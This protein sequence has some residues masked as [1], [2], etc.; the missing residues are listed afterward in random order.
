MRARWEA[1]H[2]SLSASARGLQFNLSFLE[3]KKLHPLLTDFS[4]PGR[5]VAWLHTKDGDLDAKDR[6]LSLLVALAQRGEHREL[7]TTLLWLG[8]WPG[9]DGVYRRRLKHFESQPDELVAE[10]TGAFIALIARL[11]LATVTRVA[12]TLIRSTERDLMNGR[13]RLWAEAQRIQEE[14]VAPEAFDDYLLS[15]SVKHLPVDHWCSTSTTES[16]LGLSPANS[17]EGEA[18]ALR[19]WLEPVVGDDADLLIAVLVLEESQREAGARLGLSHDAARKRF[20]RAL[21][22]VRTHLTRALSQVES[23]ARV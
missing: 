9:L 22:R 5:V 3:A 23:P 18:S 16:V 6:L 4:D 10:L 11:N 15:S 13:K 2:S 7:A 20:Q 19:E 1:L 14:L 12:A 21:C 8:L 17:D